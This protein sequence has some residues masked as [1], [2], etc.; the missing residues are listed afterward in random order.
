[1][2]ILKSNK[3]STYSRTE[4][5]LSDSGSQEGSFESG[6][7]HRFLD[8]LSAAGD[9]AGPVWFGFASKPALRVYIHGSSQENDSNEARLQQ[10][11]A[12]LTDEFLRIVS[13]T[14][15][16]YGYESIAE[17]FIRSRLAENRLAIKDWLNQLFVTYYQNEL[18]ASGVLRT[19]AHLDYAEIT[20]QGSTMALAALSHQSEE[21][22]ELGIRAFENW[23]SSEAIEALKAVRVESP[24]L[25]DYLHEVIEG[26]RTKL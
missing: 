21:I 19:I 8:F 10:Y 11:R 25:R 24:W 16:E 3:Y 26:L 12:E 20:P 13:E 15:F 22:K 7:I 9:V 2:S 14:E 23:G 6:T 18:V 1:M 5:E 4:D 17:L